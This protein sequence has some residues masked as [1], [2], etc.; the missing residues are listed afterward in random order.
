M[1]HIFLIHSSVEGHLG[2]FH[3]LV[4][5]A[6]AAINIGVQETTCVREDVEKGAP[7]YTVG[8]N[9]SWCSVEIPQEIKN[10]ASLC[11]C[12]CTTG[13]LAQRYRCREKN[14]HLYPNVYSSNGHG[15]QTVERTKMPFNRR[16]DKED[17]VHIHYGVLCLHQKG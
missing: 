7:S 11:P 8:G 9:A 12:H 17:V 14:G 10:R 16:M 4:T 5:V 2:S 1:D 6:I 13:F 3:S 15:H